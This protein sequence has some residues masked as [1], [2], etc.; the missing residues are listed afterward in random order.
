[1]VPELPGFRIFQCIAFDVKCVCGLVNLPS[2]NSI[3]PKRAYVVIVHLR[4]TLHTKYILYK[5]DLIPVK[6]FT[7]KH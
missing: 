7:T 5:P 3:N 1:M 6:K 2:S 4:T